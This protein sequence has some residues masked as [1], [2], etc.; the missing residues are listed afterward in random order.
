MTQ[1]TSRFSGTFDGRQIEILVYGDKESF[2]VRTTQKDH[3]ADASNALVIS[4]GDPID[5]EGETLPQLL[6]ALQESGFSERDSREICRL[7]Q[8][9]DEPR[10]YAF[11]HRG[12]RVEVS[13]TFGTGVFRILRFAPGANRMVGAAGSD[14]PHGATLLKSIQA[15]N[16][17]ALVAEIDRQFPGHSDL[18]QF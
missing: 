17:V 13:G 16:Q 1:W 11:E 10:R 5:I 14:Q 18:G 6:I 12:Q 2:K 7:A 4:A 3:F 15:Y 9:E 8:D